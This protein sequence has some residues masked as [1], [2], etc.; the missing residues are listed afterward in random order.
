M[1]TLID[2]TN[3]LDAD[4][5]AVIAAMNGLTQTINDLK[6]SGGDPALVAR[7]EADHQKLVA[8][9]NPQPAQPPTS[10]QSA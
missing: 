10:Q 7:L 6:A 9:L 4:T 2:V 3:E 8:A 5:D 1:A